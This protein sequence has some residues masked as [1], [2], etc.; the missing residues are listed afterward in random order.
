[1]ILS[2][3]LLEA[4]EF[5]SSHLPL[6]SCDNNPLSPLPVC[7]RVVLR[8]CATNPRDIDVVSRTPGVCVDRVHEE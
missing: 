3:P 4:V 7:N 1:M 5:S 8:T 2:H 6:I